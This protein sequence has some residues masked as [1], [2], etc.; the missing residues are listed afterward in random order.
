MKTIKTKCWGEKKE[1]KVRTRPEKNLCVT[2]VL[3]QDLL[4][5]WGPSNLILIGNF[6]Q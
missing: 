6:I 4:T 2:R 5:Y 1:T 3:N